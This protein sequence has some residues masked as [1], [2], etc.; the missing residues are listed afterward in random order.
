MARNVQQITPT[1]RQ[2]ATAI[3]ARSGPM[4]TYLNLNF[5]DGSILYLGNPITQDFKYVLVDNLGA[6]TIRVTYNR[7][8]DNLTSPIDGAKTLPTLNS[9]YIEDK[10]WHIRIYFITASQVELVM[11]SDKME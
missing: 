10:I 11:I 5:L 1:D 4:Q 7:P 6:G 3:L 2:Y 9:M 8:S